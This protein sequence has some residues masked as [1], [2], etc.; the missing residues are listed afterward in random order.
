[1]PPER[2][3]LFFSAG[4][5]EAGRPEDLLG[6]GSPRAKGILGG[7]GA[8]LHAMAE[9]GLPVPTGFTIPAACCGL[10][11]AAGGRWPEGLREELAEAVARR[12]PLP[13]VLL[14]HCGG[15]RAS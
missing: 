15:H 2:R 1:M 13:F 7:K 12:R 4:R 8:S 14:D 10:Y 3:I 11:H 5:S 6:E 9:M